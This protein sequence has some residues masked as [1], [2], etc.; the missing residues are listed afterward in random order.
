MAELSGRCF[1]GHV[2]WRSPGPVLWAGFC[3][4]DSCRRATSS[5]VTAFFGVPRGTLEWTGEMEAHPSS[6]GTAHR[7]FC[8]RCGSQ[9]SYQAERWPDE[10]HL[11]AASL[12]DPTQFEPQAHYHYGERLPWVVVED[13]LPKFKASAEAT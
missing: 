5:P 8:P 2:T 6:G 4:C 10:A 1:C 12:D 7:Y 3:H 9:M 11:Y 13:D